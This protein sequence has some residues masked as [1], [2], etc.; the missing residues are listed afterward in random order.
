VDNMP[1]IRWQ[2]LFGDNGAGGM[3]NVQKNKTRIWLPTYKDV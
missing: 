1:F 2:K 3:N